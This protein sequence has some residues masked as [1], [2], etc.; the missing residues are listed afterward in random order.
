M[1]KRLQVILQ[2][3]VYQ[4]VQRIARSRR[5]S[6]AEWFR[7]ALDLARRHESLGATGRKLEVIRTAARH[8][9][10][11]GEIDTILAEIKRGSGTG[12]HS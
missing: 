3:S 5:M 12:M 6:L 4:E 9:Y 8:D 7:R 11:T 2:D 10:P 1:A